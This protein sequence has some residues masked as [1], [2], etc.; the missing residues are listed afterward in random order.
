[1]RQL[2]LLCMLLAAVSWST[3]A[4]AQDKPKETLKPTQAELDAIAAVKKAGGAVL[5]VAQNDARLDVAFHLA[6]GKIGDDQVAAVKG[7][8]NILYSLNLRGTE[9]TDKGL[10]YLKDAKSLT[11]LHLERTKITDAGLANLAGLE[12][13]EYLNLYGTE[14][15][16]AGVQS[17]AGLKNLKRLYVWQTKVTEEGQAKFK[18]AAPNVLLVP[19]IALEKKRAELEAVRKAE[20]EAKAKVEEEA[21]KKMMEEEAKKKAEEEAKKKAEEEAKKKAADEAKKK[22]DE[23]KKKDTDKKS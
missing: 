15:S 22:E 19:D 5:Q 7:L 18:A 23:A 8:G 2:S 16:D 10:E 13:L 4:A 6:D 11:R 3:F 12:S 21:K 17:L 1:M 20:A 14:V 9:I